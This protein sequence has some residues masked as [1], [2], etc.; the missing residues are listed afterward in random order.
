MQA[1]PTSRQRRWSLIMVV[2]LFGLLL[3]LGHALLWAWLASRMEAG[4]RSWSSAHRAAG[5]QVAYDGARRG[6]WPLAATLTLPAVQVTD[7]SGLAWRSAEVELRL[8]LP[9][10][11]RLALAASGPQEF[12]VGR[13]VLPFTAASLTGSLPLLAGSR[14]W[15][16]RAESVRADSTAGPLLLR[17]MVLS[18]GAQPKG[19][20]TGMLLDLSIDGATLPV[21]VTVATVLGTELQQVVMQMMV[22]GHGPAAMPADRGPGSLAPANRDITNRAAAWRDAGGRLDLRALALQWGPVRATGNAEF[23]LDPALQPSGRGRLSLNGVDETL[24]VMVDAGLLPAAS[25]STLRALAG[26]QQRAPAPSGTL[27][28]GAQ[29]NGAPRLELPWLLRD[30]TLSVAGFSLLRLPL[31]DWP[32]Q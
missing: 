5:G 2:A 13:L 32:T 15:Q 23:G 11:D 25:A 8:A 4:L 17:G 24:R 21:P 31:L 3:M 1:K 9:W 29:G 7:A 20:T 28:D 12:A 18:L 16:V 27:G 6:G 30:R 14:P 10:P 22:T 19:Q 26:L